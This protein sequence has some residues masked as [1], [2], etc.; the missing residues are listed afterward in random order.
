MRTIHH[1]YDGVQ[2][3]E[4]EVADQKISVGVFEATSKVFQPDYYERVTILKGTICIVRKPNDE[5][6]QMF[7]EGESV[8]LHPREKYLFTCTG[9]VAYLCEYSE[10]PF[11]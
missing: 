10:E 4:T 11:T 2:S 5:S 1:D 6:Q 8:I 9:P 7:N 3:L